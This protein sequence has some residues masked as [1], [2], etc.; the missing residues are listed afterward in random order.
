[1]SRKTTAIVSRLAV[2]YFT[3][4]VRCIECN[5]DLLIPSLDTT[6]S[7]IEPESGE[8]AFSNLTTKIYCLNVKL[9]G[10]V[11]FNCLSVH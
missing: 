1:M 5:A 3:D 9:D 6:R 10:N 11:N 8:D 2:N 4:P 7:G